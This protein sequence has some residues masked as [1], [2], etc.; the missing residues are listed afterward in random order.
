MP[1]CAPLY[2]RWS[3]PLAREVRNE[4]LFGSELI[5]APITSKAARDGLARTTVWLPKGTWTDI[6]TGETFAGERLVTVKTPLDRL[7]VFAQEG[8]ILPMLAEREGNSQE[9]DAL[10]VRVFKGAGSYTMYDETGSISFATE[11]NGGVTRFDIKPSSDCK[12]ETIK[13]VSASLK[14][15]RFSVS[16]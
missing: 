6:F 1:I 4:Y 11:T 12:T 9:F 16:E 14:R 5:V 3:S 7:P 13:V 2:Y 8:A 15:A 10:E